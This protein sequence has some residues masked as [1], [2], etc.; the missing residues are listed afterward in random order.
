[1][2][3]PGAGQ[4]DIMIDSVPA[5]LSG[6]VSAGIT[7]AGRLDTAKL[8]SFPLDALEK[9]AARY[10]LVLMEGDGSQGRPLKGWAD[11]EPVVP[12]FTDFTVG[13]IPI[14]PLGLPVSE[15][16]VHRLALFSALT[17]A[18]G[19]DIVR[20][21]HLVSLVTGAFPPGG[22]RGLFAAARG[23]KILFINQVEDGEEMKKAEDLAAMLPGAFRKGLY[24]VLA[25]SVRLD[26]VAVL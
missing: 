14:R 4:Y 3:I 22:G 10:D 6:P 26:G 21:A 9:A 1:M 16:T 23:K 25:G 5:L 15:A 8:L 18:A 13:I 19:G 24:A 17:G 11:W 12:S 2:L 7:V 20:P